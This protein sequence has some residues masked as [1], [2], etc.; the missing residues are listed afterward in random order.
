M[1]G[2][3][4]SL[5]QRQL[6][7]RELHILATVVEAGSMAKAAAQLSIAQPSVSEVIANLEALLNVRL[8]DRSPRGVEPTAYAHVLVKRGRA[9]F[10]ELGQAIREIEFLSD[11]TKGEVRIGCAESFAAGLV[12]AIV[13]RT[14][15]RYPQFNF[16]VVEANTAASNF[17]ELRER[18]VDLMLG[19]LSRSALDDDLSADVLFED[20]FFVVAGADNPLARRRKV[21][22][23]EL[24]DESW[25]LGQSDNV[26]R[27]LVTE[28]LRRVGAAPPKVT[29]TTTSM[30]V[31][32]HLLGASR[33]LTVFHGSLLH[34]NAHRW[35]LRVLPVDLGKR[36]P[37]AI[38]TLKGRSLSPSAQL[39]IE[40]A[41][42]ITSL[43]LRPPSNRQ[44]RQGM[45]FGAKTQRTPS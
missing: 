18:N 24:A 21:T 13:E 7:L 29:M 35:S 32:L 30:H 44:A 15:R 25:M 27:L 41:R 40:N 20:S 43:L 45:E 6:K 23:A 3:S 37:V 22:L 1:S 2:K 17:Q 4:L 31:R 5:K 19:N 36:L 12:P 9:V 10:D 33:F 8:L 39:F 34:Y 14:L 26:V 11:P 28:A 42:S 38:V 16:H